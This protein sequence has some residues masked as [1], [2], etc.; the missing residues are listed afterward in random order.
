M[1][2]PVP[3]CGDLVVVAL[4]DNVPV[5][6]ITVSSVGSHIVGNQVFTVNVDASAL[7]NALSGVLTLEASLAGYPSVKLALT[8]KLTIYKLIFGQMLAVKYQT[9]SA[10]MKVT[11]NYFL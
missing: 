5:T 7:S 11:F 1:V 2:N 3:D 9:N 10:E 6:W 4:L 8:S